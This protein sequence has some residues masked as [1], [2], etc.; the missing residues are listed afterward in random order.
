MPVPAGA[1]Y[2]LQNFH[3]TFI[4]LGPLPLALVLKAMLG[5]RGQL[6]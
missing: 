1:N 3:D 4:R 2:S 6:F 5:D